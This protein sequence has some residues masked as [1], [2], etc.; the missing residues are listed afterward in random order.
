MLALRNSAVAPSLPLAKPAAA[1]A[2]RRGVLGAGRMLGARARSTC[3]GRARLTGPPL[4]CP[5]H[6]SP[7]GVIHTDFEKGF[8]RAETIAYGDYVKHKGYGGS[9]E[10][11]ALRL[12]GKEY[13][14]QEGD[15]LLFRFNV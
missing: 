15:V 3:S 6:P 13:V 14:V 1:V 7:P 11:G 8:I 2:R 10:N 4:P 5:N 12:E 9:K